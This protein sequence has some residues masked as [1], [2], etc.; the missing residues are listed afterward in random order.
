MNSNG[1]LLSTTAKLSA[2]VLQN[3]QSAKDDVEIE[4]CVI[5]GHSEQPAGL[6]I[7]RIDGGDIY[8]ILN[9]V[10]PVEI[11]IE[12]DL[13][14]LICPGWASP[15]SVE[16]PSSH[17]KRTRVVVVV[18]LDL[19]TGDMTTQIIFMDKREPVVTTERPAGPLGDALMSCAVRISTHRKEQ[20][21]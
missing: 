6:R 2:Y 17:P 15:M 1:E 20:L 12:A 19:K 9:Q 8:A 13:V 5:W 18:V 11:P 21:H 3:S 7:L 14:G 16:S 4:P 10:S